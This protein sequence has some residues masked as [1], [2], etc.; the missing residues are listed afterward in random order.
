M[1]RRASATTSS[2]VRGSNSPQRWTSSGTTAPWGATTF[3]ANTGKAENAGNKW[4]N[5]GQKDQYASTTFTSTR[6]QT[7]V[8]C[9]VKPIV[10][11]RFEL[12]W[13][14]LKPKVSGSRDL[15]EPLQ[16]FKVL[17]Y[18]AFPVGCLVWWKSV[19]AQ[20]PDEWEAKF[21]NLQARPNREN[22]TMAKQESYFD[23]IDTL[24]QKREEAMIRKGH[25]G[26]TSG[27]AP[28]MPAKA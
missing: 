6:V 18:L 21:S 15:L 13:D 11:S 26:P 9:R 25:S 17:G 22:D 1:W 5:V 7:K 20:Y 27:Q 28:P 12:L 10:Q 8:V 14:Y 3:N 24:E 23:V 4:K 2:T 16:I 19:Y